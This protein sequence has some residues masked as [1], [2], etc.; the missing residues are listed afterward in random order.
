HPRSGARRW[1]PTTRRRAEAVLEFVR[2]RGVVHPREVDAHFAHGRVTNYWGGSSNATTHLLDNMHYRGLLRVAK[3]DNGIRLYTAHEHAARPSHAAARKAQV[4]ALVDLVVRKYAPL[5]ASSLGVLV[6]LLRYGAPQWQAEL[7]PAL[8]RAR[9]RLAHAR[10]DGADWYWPATE[11]PQSARHAPRDEVRLLAP[12]DPI[13]WDRRRFELFWDWAYRF[14]AYT[15]APQRKLGYYA[16]PLLWGDR[17]IGWGNVA[18]KEG[19]LLPAF[20]Y[21]EGAAPRGAV[22][23]RELDAEI[24]RLHAFLAIS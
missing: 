23:R 11:R 7:K 12:F 1:N 19:R 8:Q 14:E 5:P 24:E 16:L 21:V 6:R 9:A 2:E 13:V 17:V 20:G 10:L 4:D 18:V 22:F 3:R 15:P